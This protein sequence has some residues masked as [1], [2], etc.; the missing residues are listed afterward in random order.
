MPE[1]LL[2]LM[3]TGIKK[4]SVWKTRFVSEYFDIVQSKSSDVL[5]S[6][7]ALPVAAL[8]IPAK[9]SARANHVKSAKHRVDYFFHVV[10]LTCTHL[11]KLHEVF[12]SPLFEE[13]WFPARNSPL[14]FFNWLK[15]SDLLSFA[16]SYDRP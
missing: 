14:A 5:H 7:H 11:H 12:K 1:D 8:A 10:F 15:T 2:L 13:I 4:T 3:T 6:L 9:S 16:R